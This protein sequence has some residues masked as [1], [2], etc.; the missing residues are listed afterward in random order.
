M[1]RDDD[2]GVDLAQDPMARVVDEHLEYLSGDR[3]APPSLSGLRG[4]ERREAAELLEL[5]EANWGTAVAVPGPPSTRPTSASPSPA[6]VAAPR[7]RTS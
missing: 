2:L 7:T 6:A 3:D 4:P 5:L 1:R